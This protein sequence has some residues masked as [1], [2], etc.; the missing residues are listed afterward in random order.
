MSVIDPYAVDQ[1]VRPLIKRK[2]H[3]F[4]SKEDTI[5]ELR[6]QIVEAW[7]MGFESGLRE[8]PPSE[9]ERER[10]KAILS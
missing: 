4:A 5:R 10:C 1:M 7:F 3:G 9:E 2:A 8:T 6:R